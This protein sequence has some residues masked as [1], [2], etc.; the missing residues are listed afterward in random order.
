MSGPCTRPECGGEVHTDQWG[1]PVR[2]PHTST[3]SAP[4]I[5]LGA[6]FVVDSNVPSNVIEFRRQ[7]PNIVILS[8]DGHPL[9]TIK[10]NGELKY[11]P[12][13]TPDEAARCFWDALRYLAPAR[14]P[15][16]GHIGLEAP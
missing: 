6:S 11:G 16:C 12:G 7:P 2:C 15:A 5:D 3:A 10:P 8:E 13:Y 9:V 4:P 14:C 1:T